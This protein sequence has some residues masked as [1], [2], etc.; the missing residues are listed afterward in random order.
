[1][2]NVYSDLKY[3]NNQNIFKGHASLLTVQMLAILHTLL[4][5]RPSKRVYRVYIDD[6]CSGAVITRI[7][8]AQNTETK[9]VHFPPYVI[10]YYLERDT[11]FMSAWYEE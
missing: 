2:N 9:K 4:T 10:V 5:H 6:V 11:L 8:R 1:M 3:F 7:R